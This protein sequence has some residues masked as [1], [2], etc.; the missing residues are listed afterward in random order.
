MVFTS[1]SLSAELLPTHEN[2]TEPAGFPT[3]SHSVKC[4]LPA[5]VF[6]CHFHRMSSDERL[7]DGKVAPAPPFSQLS[8]C[9]CCDLESD[10][11]WEKKRR[12]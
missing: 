10:P 9:A 8:P 7:A 5:P 12:D 4:N 3:S 11:L 2:Q 6:I 1:F